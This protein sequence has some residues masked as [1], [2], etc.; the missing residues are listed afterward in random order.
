MTDKPRPPFM[1][2]TCF[3]C[4]APEI[5]LQRYP[6]IACN[7]CVSRAVNWEGK[8]VQFFNA[9]YGAGFMAT[10]EGGSVD[11][12]TTYTHT[13]YIDGT[14]VFVNEARFGGTVVEPIDLLPESWR[15]RRPGQHKPGQ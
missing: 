10:F 15:D 12:D 1:E 7:D 4:G 14:P 9:E 3:I 8:P 6:S 2:T 5:T 11:H 13:A